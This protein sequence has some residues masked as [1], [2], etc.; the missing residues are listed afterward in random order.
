MTPTSP[1]SRWDYARAGILTAVI[2]L[3]LLDAIPLPDLRPHHLTNPVAWEELRRWT[4]TLNRAGVDISERELADLGLDVGGAARTFRRRVLQPWE[5]FRWVTGTGQNWSLFAIPESAVGRLVV[6]GVDTA[7]NRTTFY[8]AP[9]GESDH[10]EA[11][12]E[13]RR[14]RGVYDGACDRPKPRKVYAQ[15]GK[16]LS[17]HLMAE[18]PELQ[19]VEVRL[20]LHR[21]RTPGEEPA[22]PDERRHARMYTRGELVRDGFLEGGP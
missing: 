3:Q 4:H 6:E 16:W 19:L 8:R 9:G 14:V 18:H 11:M 20:D 12:L 7:G 1:P 13:Y 21:I 15:F 22:P 17:A 10:L 2:A 5:P